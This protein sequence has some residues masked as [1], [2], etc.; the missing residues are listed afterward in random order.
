MSN[1]FAE[2]QITSGRASPVTDF[3]A[4]SEDGFEVDDFVALPV[5]TSGKLGLSFHT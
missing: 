1:V 2:D 4:S 3:A 5:C